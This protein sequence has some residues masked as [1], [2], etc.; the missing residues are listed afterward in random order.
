MSRETKP[1]KRLIG[2][3]RVSTESQDLA[4]QT[5]ALKRLGCAP[6]YSDKASGKSMAGRPELARALDDLDSGD[7]LVIAEWDRA[8]RSMWDGLQIIKTVIDAGASIKVL[9]RSYIDLTTPMGRGFMAMMSAMAE[10]E[11]LRI[12]KR[13]GE[14]RKIAQG[15][16]IRMG[17]KPKLT[18]HQMTE[19]RRRLAEGETTR[20][21]AK[22]YGVSRSTIARLINAI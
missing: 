17:R 22:S 8:T 14:G 10:D 18:P 5:K 21:L 2:Y 11:R 7:E 20:A 13:T 19:A 15:K 4:R 6:I 9:D 16:G 12:I 3:A 1:E